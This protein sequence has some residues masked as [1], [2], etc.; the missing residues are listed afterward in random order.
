MIQYTVLC[1]ATY[2]VE[3]PVCSL[4]ISIFTENSNM[5]LVQEWHWET[6]S[7]GNFTFAQ[8][9]AAYYY[10]VQCAWLLWMVHETASSSC[11]WHCCTV[12]VYDFTV[13]CYCWA[14]YIHN[15]LLL[16]CLQHRTQT[17]DRWKLNTQA[18]GEPGHRYFDLIDGGIYASFTWH[19]QS[20]NDRLQYWM[21]TGCFSSPG[22]ASINTVLRMFCFI[23]YI[24]KVID[25]SNQ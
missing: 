8:C 9:C 10:F 5:V 15:I 14:L 18:S 20:N 25:T 19:Q 1:L 21:Q 4:Y 22:R 16:R 2:M 7:F 13:R 11:P 17:Q 12:L 24:W 3:Q 6:H 23:N